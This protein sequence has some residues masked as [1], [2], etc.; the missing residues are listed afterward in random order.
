[1]FGMQVLVNPTVQD[2]ELYLKNGQAATWPYITVINQMLCLETA[3]DKAISKLQSQIHLGS[4]P[5]STP[6]SPTKSTHLATSAAN[7]N[8]SPSKELVLEQK[9]KLL[10]AEVRSLREKIHFLENEKKREDTTEKEFFRIP[11]D[12]EED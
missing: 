1:M 6:N 8:R 12:G 9:V 3:I 4:Y 5:P 10:E 7:G 11:E 2:M